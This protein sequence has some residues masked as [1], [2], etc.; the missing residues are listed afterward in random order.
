MELG[1]GT[2]YHSKSQ[3]KRSHG[4]PKQAQFHVF[5]THFWQ[6]LANVSYWLWDPGSGLLAERR[7]APNTL[8]NLR[9]SLVLGRGTGRRWQKPYVFIGFSASS[10]KNTVFYKVL[11]GDLPR[12]GCGVTPPVLY[13]IRQNPFS[14][15]T[16][17]GTN[18][19]AK[20]G[21]LWLQLN[22]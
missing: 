2:S 14:A 15:S 9:F 16:V 4:D 19:W 22:A 10:A 8:K 21:M 1:P 6:H 13:Q 17:W 3:P 18:C 7:W 12:A 20:T 11:R 5:Q